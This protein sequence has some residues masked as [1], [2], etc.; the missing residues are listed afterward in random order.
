MAP[1]SD[2]TELETAWHALASQ[3]AEQ[4]ALAAA[5]RSHDADHLAAIHRE[6]EVI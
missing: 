3:S 5:A 4:R 1:R 6:I 2:E